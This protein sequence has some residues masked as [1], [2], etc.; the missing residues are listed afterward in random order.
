MSA[1][2]YLASLD[3]PLLIVTTNY[4]DLIER[5]FDAKGKKYDVVIH[6]TDPLDNARLLWWRHGHAE[7][8]KVNPKKLLPPLETTTYIYKMHGGVDRHVSTRD[9]YVITEDDY[10]EF[11]SRMIKNTAIPFTFAEAFA[12][13]HFLFLGYGLR[14][15]NL[16][17][18]LNNIEKHSRRS[19][20]NT[21][22]AVQH[23]PSPLER[24]FWQERGVEVY[25]LTIDEFV[26]ELV[27]FLQ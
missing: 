8:V 4:D 22:W 13:R 9:Q 6:T 26:R 20:E 15:W 5:A 14:D 25:D 27:S 19:R 7:P 3:T 16:R 18:V 11:L 17:V 24:R 21:S 1:H 23:E 12:T 10:I 2:L